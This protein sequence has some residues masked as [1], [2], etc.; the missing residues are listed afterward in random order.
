MVSRAAG[1]EADLSTETVSPT[2]LQDSAQGAKL[3][4]V[5]GGTGWAAGLPDL[6]VYREVLY[7]MLI[8]NLKIRFRQALL[9]AAWAVLQPI[10]LMGVLVFVAHVVFNAPSQGVPYPLFAFAALVPWTLF[11]QSLTVA[12]ESIVRDMNLVSK[13]YIPRLIIPLAAI[14]VL[15]VDF[16]IAFGFLLIMMA[17][18]TWPPGLAALAWV[19]ATTLLALAVS[20]GVGV[21]L[22]A[23]M[24]LYRDVRWVVPLLVQVWLFATPVAYSATLVP[25]DWQLLY[26]LNPMAGVVEGFRSGLLGTNAPPSDMLAVSGAVAVFLLVGAFTYFRRVDRIFA[27]VI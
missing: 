19:P 16:V 3:I 4:R 10:A 26:Y 20:V 1:P 9:G 14:G 12:A 6:W 22:S 21:W 24:V 18:Y 17:L 2:N 5:Q 25:A 8:R 11:S 27:D 13:V 23:L 7:F 15:I